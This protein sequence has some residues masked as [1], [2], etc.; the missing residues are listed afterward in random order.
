MMNT[1]FLS[2]IFFYCVNFLL[3][4]SVSV[5]VD[6]QGKVH[7]P[8]IS[9]A[10]VPVHAHGGKEASEPVVEG[11]ENDDASKSDNNYYD[12]LKPYPKSRQIVADRIAFQTC[13][14]LR[15]VYADR[16][17]LYS[18]ERDT[19]CT[20]GC[21]FLPSA[22]ECTSDDRN[23]S[24]SNRTKRD[25][26]S[27]K[28][29]VFIEDLLEGKETLDEYS[30]GVDERLVETWNQILW[31][32]LP[33]IF[34]F[35]PIMLNQYKY[36]NYWWATFFIFMFMLFNLFV[37]LY[38]PAMAL[39]H[40][41]ISLLCLTS[42]ASATSLAE[43]GAQIVVML[44][45]LLLMFLMDPVVQIICFLIMIFVV[46][47]YVF[48]TF[49]VA[50]RGSTA[51]FVVTICQLLLLYEQLE[52]I[53]EDYFLH[54]IVSLGF[55]ML[56]NVAMIKGKSQWFYWNVGISSIR[57]CKLLDPEWITQRA[58]CVV[59]LS[60]FQLI[61]FVAFRA[62]FGMYCLNSLRY[63]TDMHS[64]LHGLCIYLADLL[65]G[66]TYV[67]RL[68]MGIEAFNSRRA[69]FACVSVMLT[70]HEFY[71]A[72]ELIIIK[73]C[74]T[75]FDYSI[76][77]KRFNRVPRYL[78]ENIDFGG[79]AFPQDGSAPWIAVDNLLDI[80]KNTA[81]LTV[82]KT[83][84]AVSGMGVVISNNGR[85][86]LY[87][88]KHVIDGGNF[89]NFLGETYDELTFNPLNRSSDDPVVV[90]CV[91]EPAN[92]VS[93]D[94]VVPDEL[95]L[96]RHLTFINCDENGDSYINFVDNFSVI[97]DEIKASINLRNGD[98]GGPVF[99]ILPDG[100]L[101]YC[102]AVSKGNTN[103]G[104]GNVISLACG[105][106]S[107]SDSDSDEDLLSNSKKFN[108]MRKLFDKNERLTQKY[109]QANE[110]VKLILN[111]DSMR[112]AISMFDN[113][114]PFI[115]PDDLFHDPD[116]FVD[117]EYKNG[118]PPWAVK[119]RS[120]EDRV[121][122]AKLREQ[123][124]AGVFEIDIKNMVHDLE[125]H[126]G[127]ALDPNDVEDEFIKRKKKKRRKN[128]YKDKAARKRNFIMFK[129]LRYTLSEVYDD[130]EKVNNIYTGLVKSGPPTGFFGS[131]YLLEQ[132]N[133][134][135]RNA[136]N[137]MTSDE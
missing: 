127:D 30:F 41:V 16:M 46:M 100:T 51:T 36:Y 7:P 101:R 96:I 97:R 106:Q 64:F 55:E 118:P 48:R 68:I 108:K 13:R 123:V 78:G 39:H 125:K 69:S 9:K 76:G 119:F 70:Y 59:V 20:N 116:D 50:K 111:S 114:T 86:L 23:G 53:R 49:F 94:V 44:V 6:S 83:Q 122:D 62:C 74:F 21:S 40:V 130:V 87:T 31:G 113:G 29:F 37:G 5:E 135:T 88:V 11:K 120:E 105:E 19:Y 85:N 89:Y 60:L 82:G 42:G 93:V 90:A 109:R 124:D 126:K 134:G 128:V 18:D 10:P 131:S 77:K 58:L 22:F 61:S 136:G 95:S 121:L 80:A 63:K 57:I 73:I 107:F 33:Y 98:S 47:L 35:L 104:A 133:G 24:R 137:W 99:G 38:R 81:K 15:L 92:A 84:K 52:I 43:V 26:F 67:F 4:D 45:F 14:K 71:S 91:N 27:D 65:S 25:S 34:V 1:L 102:G 72:R 2:I 28:L 8:D 32:F 54:N 132:W 115:K 103:R 79:A 66:I 75:A 17:Y 3:A 117:A 56:L 110:R 112:E 12:D 129:T